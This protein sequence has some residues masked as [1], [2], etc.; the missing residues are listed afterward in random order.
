MVGVA[1]VWARVLA[2]S[3]PGVLEIVILLA[4]VFGFGLAVFCLEARGFTGAITRGPRARREV[5]LTFDDGPD[6]VSTPAVLDTLAS[7]GARATFFVVG[8]EA[9]RHPELIARMLREG[10][11]VESHGYRHRWRDLVGLAGARRTIG[12][13]ARV[14]TE[15][16]GQRTGY[17]RPPYGVMTPALAVAAAAL[18]VRIVGWSCRGFDTLGR[19]AAKRARRLARRFCKGCII[20]LHDA[21]MM[22]GGRTPLGPKMLPL[23]LSELVRQDLVPVTLRELL[24]ETKG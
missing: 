11:E 22:P 8:E 13:G 10:H 2:G 18:D 24:R 3:T 23:V 17:F 7:F 15:L 16:T 4:L 21:A 9:E 14:L 5:A 6:E 20:L 1:L 19:S 12:E